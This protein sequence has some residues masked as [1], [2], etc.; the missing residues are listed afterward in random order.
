MI[1]PAYST[2]ELVD[3]V[4][5]EPDDPWDLPALRDTGVKWSGEFKRKMP[6]SNKYNVLNV[7]MMMS[8]MCT[9]QIWIL[10]GKYCELS[11][12]LRSCV[13]Y[14]DFSTCLSALWMFSVQLFSLLEVQYI[15]FFVVILIEAMVC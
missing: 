14:L 15:S 11:L 6:A 4:E 12:E 2:A 3:D 10:R 5:Q 7:L 1:L 8:F 9:S 13:Y